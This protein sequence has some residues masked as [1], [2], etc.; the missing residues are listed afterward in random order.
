[1]TGHVRPARADRARHRLRHAH[2]AVPHGNE[3]P[4]ERA[5][6]RRI[7]QAHA[8]GVVSLRHQHAVLIDTGLRW[9]PAAYRLD[10]V[11][12]RATSTAAATITCFF[13]RPSNLAF[14][15]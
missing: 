9:T 14:D 8:G 11:A 2:P 13:P 6:H 3:I 5:A 10:R 12:A 1:G 7:G 4:A 15:P